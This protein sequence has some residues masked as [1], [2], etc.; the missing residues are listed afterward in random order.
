M[1][2]LEVRNLTFAY[3]GKAVFSDLNFTLQKGESL[4]I[5]GANGAGKTTLLRILMRFLKKT[6]GEIFLDDV[7]YE[8]I[9]D[10]AFFDIFSY[11][12]Q[13]AGDALSY[14][15]LETVLFGKT[16]AVSL[17]SVP[18]KKDIEEAEELLR[19][20]GIGFLRDRTVDTL[21][22]GERQMVY[23]ARALIKKPEIIVLD[24]PES[25]LDFRNQM[26]VLDTL[27]QLKK[28]GIGFIFNTHYPE[29]SEI[30]EKTLLLSGSDSVFG[31]T[32]EIITEENIRKIFGVRA[33]IREL[34]TDGI[35]KRIIVPFRLSDDNDT[36]YRFK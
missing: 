6:G 4:S 28:E 15:V 29:H 17:F 23:I 22:G 9:S 12:P 32:E 5:L 27:Q 24:E 20:L 7:P 26:I 25:G 11:V 35:K 18:G 1:K 34:E 30:A 10:K 16:N 14:T 33:E 21:S 2:K 13:R 31:A 8:K 19:R 3:P 36:G